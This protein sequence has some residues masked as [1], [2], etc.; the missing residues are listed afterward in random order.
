MLP[1]RFPVIAPTLKVVFKPVRQL[2]SALSCLPLAACGALGGLGSGT[3]S[4]R[5]STPDQYYVGAATSISSLEPDTSESAVF[6]LDDSSDT[7]FALTF[8]R[9]FTTRL[10]AEVRYGELGEATLSPAASVDYAF[11]GV[12]GLYYVF[13]DEYLINRREGFAVFLRGGI[14]SLMNDATIALDEEDNT[15]IVAGAGVDYRFSNRWG[16]RGEYN[17]HDT[18]AQAAHIGIVYR[19]GVGAEDKP[20]RVPPT[21]RI[22]DPV[23][24]PR[25]P[26]P[27]Q[28][29]P[30]SR[31]DVTRAPVSRPQIQTIPEPQPEQR[32]PQPQ[33]QPRP[34][35]QS[36]PGLL[37]NGILRGVRFSPSSALLN[38]DARSELDRLAS[39]LARNPN[40]M[41]ELFAHT[42]GARGP[43][44]ALQLARAR[45][46]QVGR[47]LINKGV[48]PRRIQARAF[49]SNRP[50]SNDP[51]AQVNNRIELAISNQ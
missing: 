41:I 32:L 5:A 37:V 1:M 44:F 21:A 38:V 27:S 18:D 24:N 6:S 14:N 34:S 20:A 47:Y 2:C 13:G 16:V 19:F 7:G 10:S 51:A 12:S 29:P 39:E 23:Q 43:D 3:E 8:G 9:D 49:G 17:F 22:P 50:M 45:V 46:T 36:G 15:Q 31:P 11:I 28:R 35:T 26:L 40:V 25:N 33:V 30:I 48:S 42:D 4:D